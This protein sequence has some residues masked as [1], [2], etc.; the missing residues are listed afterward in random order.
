LLRGGK[1]HD[2]LETTLDFSTDGEV[3]IDMKD[4]VAKNAEAPT[5]RYGRR[6]DNASS[7][8]PV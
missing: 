4:Y 7:T 5:H 3:E 2:Y 6:G 1:K 8:T